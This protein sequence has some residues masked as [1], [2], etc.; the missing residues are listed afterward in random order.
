MG[1]GTVFPFRLLRK[2]LSRR[3]LEFSSLSGDN[4]VCSENSAGYLLPTGVVYVFLAVSSGKTRPLTHRLRHWRS[5]P[6]VPERP[7]PALLAP[8]PD[9]LTAITIGTTTPSSRQSGRVRAGFDVV[10]TVVGAPPQPA[11]FFLLP[12]S[13]TPERRLAVACTL[14]AKCS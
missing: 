6:P 13:T 4:I 10:T 8:S 1:I 14:L 11:F 9:G 2:P 12:F 3:L 5:L 7:L